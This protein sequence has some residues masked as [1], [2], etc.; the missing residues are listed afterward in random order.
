[1][2]FTPSTIGLQPSA[3]AQSTLQ[4]AQWAIA[5]GTADSITAAYPT[6][7]TALT[8]GLILGF[9]ASAP[10]AT[11]TPGFAPDGLASHTITKDGGKPLLPGDIPNAGAEVLV[12]YNLANTRWELLNPD[13]LSGTDWAVA[14]G[15]AD[16]IAAAYSPPNA[17]LFDGMQLR[18]RA[19]GTNAT[20]TPTFAP[21]GQTP[22]TIVKRGSTALVAG[23]IETSGEY[24]VTYNLANT[25]WVLMNPK[26]TP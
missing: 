9:R 4:T 13:Q 17:T 6:P 5:A 21:D 20:T 15:T 7:N 23:D 24:V 8:D 12:R 16:A 1:M 22:R 3:A 25:R 2:V 26:N 18:F 19:T 10:N 14:T 11:A